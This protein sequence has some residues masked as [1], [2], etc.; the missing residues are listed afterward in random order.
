MNDPKYAYPYPPPNQ[1]T[2][3]TSESYVLHALKFPFS[4]SELI[5]YTVFTST[6]FFVTVTI[7]ET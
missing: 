2:L 5:T 7:D 4:S 1:G 6:L 3:P